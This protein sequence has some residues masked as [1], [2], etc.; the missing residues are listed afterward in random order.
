MGI[1]SKIKELFKKESQEEIKSNV[2]ENHIEEAK[3]DLEEEKIEVVEEKN[4]EVYE[5]GLTKSR[6]GFVSRLLNLTNKYKS[7]T[8]EYFEELEEIL[9]MADVGVNTVMD[10]I[11]RLKKRVKHENITDLEYLGCN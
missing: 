10:F 1:F 5:K 8:E 2:N 9:I 3:T 11:D 7:A 6:E 4:V